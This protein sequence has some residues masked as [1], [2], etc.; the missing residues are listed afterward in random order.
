MEVFYYS[1]TDEGLAALASLPE[2]MDEMPLLWA[3]A[4]DE[5]ELAA[6]YASLTGS[7]LEHS[8]LLGRAIEGLGL[9]SV[10]IDEQ[11]AMAQVTEHLIAQGHRRLA[12]LGSDPT[13]AE[14]WRRYRGFA[15]SMWDHG[16]D[17]PLDWVFSS[18]AG[19]K[20]DE[21]FERVMAGSLR[22][23]AVVCSTDTRAVQVIHRLASIGLSC[24]SDVAVTGMGDEAFGAFLA[25]PLTTFRFDL[26]EVARQVVEAVNG[27]QQGRVVVSRPVT[28]ELVVRT[29]CGARSAGMAPREN[30]P[31]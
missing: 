21:R 14:G 24:P 19:V 12:Y 16:L 11:A 28:G 10:G 30:A 1:D 25:E 20:A 7:H 4:G 27:L 29:S 26:V 6:R 13:Q 22:P 5:E 23:T 9:P 15:A 3:V 31:V 17:L 2:D 8:L 18:E